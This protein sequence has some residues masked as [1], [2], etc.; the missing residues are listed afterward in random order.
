MIITPNLSNLLHLN[1]YTILII[2]M[3]RIKLIGHFVCLFFP[4]YFLRDDFSIWYF[5]HSLMDYGWQMIFLFTS[6][7]FR[8]RCLNSPGNVSQ[9][10]QHP[11]NRYQF[12]NLWFVLK[13]GRLS[14]FTP[15]QIVVNNN[16]SRLITFI[17]VWT[18]ALVNTCKWVILFYLV[19]H[20]QHRILSRSSKVNNTGIPTPSIV[21]LVF[22]LDGCTVCMHLCEFGWFSI[23]V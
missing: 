17:V 13:I 19:L 10:Y 4:A 5:F 9:T 23:C 22:A 8:V 14:T 18:R 6:S 3:K 16:I 15:I 21:F 7:I 2:I 11:N 20:H 12:R 1:N